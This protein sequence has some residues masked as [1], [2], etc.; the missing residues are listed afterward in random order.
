MP[1]LFIQCGGDFIG[2]SVQFLSERRHILAIQRQRSRDLT[3]LGEQSQHRAQTLLLPGIE[4]EQVPG[5]GARIAAGTTPRGAGEQPLERAQDS[6]LEVCTLRYN[7]RVE[8][9]AVGDRNIGQKLATVQRQR[10][11]EQLGTG[12]AR[13]PATMRVRLRTRHQG[14]KRTCIDDHR[15]RRIEAN[16]M[17]IAE[18]H[19]YGGVFVAQ[20]VRSVVSAWLR[21]ARAR[22]SGWSGQSSVAS[23]ARV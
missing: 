17:R 15:P 22:C 20:S 21:L 16:G 7:P 12:A 13:A 1:N 5:V 4:R 8:H 18:Q 10:L 3:V 14:D 2:F 6:L 9:V 11:S 23:A 19:G